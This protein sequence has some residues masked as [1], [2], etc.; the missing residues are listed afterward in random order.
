MSTGPDGAVYLGNSPL[1]RIIARVLG[2]STAPLTGGVSKFASDRAALLMRDAACAAEARA[3]NAASQTD[4]PDGITADTVQIGEL[5]AQIRA[6]APAA[7]AEGSL[8]PP[9]WARLDRRLGKAEPLLATAAADPTKRRALAHA[10]N[11]IRGVC[12][13]LARQ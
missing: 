9:Q 12:H 3:R 11:R 2:L 8:R 7:I 13:T 6:T 5:I 4:C 1:R 10:A